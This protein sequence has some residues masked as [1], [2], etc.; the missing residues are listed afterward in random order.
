MKK[1]K[2][3]KKLK[4][5]KKNELKKIKGGLSRDNIMQRKEIK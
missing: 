5:I 4:K 3:V 1:A 2:N